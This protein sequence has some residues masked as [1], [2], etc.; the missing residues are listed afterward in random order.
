MDGDTRAALEA[1][2]AALAR[3]GAWD[4]LASRAIR[5]YGP[6][7]L[8]FLVALTRDPDDADDVFS[9]FLT[10]LWRGLPGFT[11]ASSFRT[12]AYRVA[13]RA[14]HRFAR[15]QR[16]RGQRRVALSGA[17]ELS[18]IAAKVHTTTMIH[19]RTQ[20]KDR[21]S[22]LREA[23]APD[24]Q[25]LLILRVNRKMTWSEIATIL[26]PGDPAAASNARQTAALRKRYERI[27]AKLRTMAHAEGIA[28]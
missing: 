28:D 21:V 24:D 8:G 10:D 1:E 27:V 3:A 22:K 26:A 25:M 4:S 7:L 18:A 2:L 9:M 20:V 23:L 11:W 19:L 6:E 5:G 16:R 12:W 15:D 17:P 14:L 13:Q